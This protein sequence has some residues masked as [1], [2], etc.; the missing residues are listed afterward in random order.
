MIQRDASNIARTLRTLAQRDG[1]NALRGLKKLTMRDAGNVL[2]V[3]YQSLSATVSTTSVSGIGSSPG[4]ITV[5]A[6]PVTCS[7]VDGTG[8]FTFEWET[9]APDWIITNP[10]APTTSFRATGLGPGAYETADF[11][12]TVTDATGAIATSPVVTAT[13]QNVNGA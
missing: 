1:S 7:A 8:P 10:T 9:L 3:I 6:G 4:S 13:A 11:T 2:R 12:C 5:T